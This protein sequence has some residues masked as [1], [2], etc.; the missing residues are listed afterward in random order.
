MVKQNTAA[1][2]QAVSF[3]VI[4]RQLE[5]AYFADAIARSGMKT[6]ALI[7]RQLFGF[8]EHFARTGEVK[9]A[10]GNQV[11]DRGKQKVSAVDI[12]VESRKLVVERVADEA[13]R[14]QVITFVGGHFGDQLI[15]TGEAFERRG[16]QTN[17]FAHGVQTHQPV[18]RVLQSHAPHSTVDLIALRQQQF[19][20]IGS[21]LPGNSGNQ[22]PAAHKRIT[23]I[24]DGPVANA[25]GAAEAQPLISPPEHLS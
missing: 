2:V 7:L 13:L 11:F 20:E 17:P 16:V 9:L 8:A 10:A 3:A 25:G 22:R 12:C 4:A 5:A 19:R 18:F 21:I 1:G 23:I 15:D 14:R 24:R 6:G